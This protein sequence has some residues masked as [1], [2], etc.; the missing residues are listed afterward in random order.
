VG[1]EVAE[2]DDE[3]F[4]QKIESLVAILDEQFRESARLEQLIRDN[5]RAL[6][7]AR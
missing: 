3:P 1:T 5:L 2:D 7:H 4:D 6:C